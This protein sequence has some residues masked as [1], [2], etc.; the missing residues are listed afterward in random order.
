MLKPGWGAIIWL[1]MLTTPVA[2]AELCASSYNDLALTENL[3]KLKTLFVEESQTGLV[4]A[5]RGSFV[6]VDTAGETLS[7]TF[8]TSGLFDLY[9]I[10]KQGP[11]QFCDLDGVVYIKALQRSDQIHFSE[12]GFSLGGGGPRLQ[13]QR[14][15]MPDLLKRLHDIPVRATAS[16]K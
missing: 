15:E 16:D 2:S 13:F 10:R 6:T 8:Y 4:N 12:S 9:P 14:G 7:I 11:L 1:L 3:Q 5:T